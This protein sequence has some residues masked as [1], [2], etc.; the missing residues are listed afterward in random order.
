M[1]RAINIALVGFNGFRY[2]NNLKYL[3]EKH[4]NHKFNFKVVET[5]AQV[6]FVNADSPEGRDHLTRHQPSFTTL[7]ASEKPLSDSQYVINKPIKSAAIHQLLD[8][9]GSAFI[10]SQHAH[11][12]DDANTDKKA[13]QNVTKM[14]E[15]FVEKSDKSE[16][17]LPGG[18]GQAKEELRFYQPHDYLQGRILQALSKNKGSDDCIRFIKPYSQSELLM[19]ISIAD[20]LVYMPEGVNKIDKF[21]GI[22]MAGT[23]VKT[24]IVQM[25]KN[26]KSEL[27]SSGCMSLDK[28]IWDS[29]VGASLGRLP[30]STDSSTTIKMKYWPNLSRLKLRGG[31]TQIAALW[32]QNSYSI[33]QVRDF[34]PQYSQ[35]INAFYAAAS[36]L[37]LFEGGEHLMVTETAKKVDKGLFNRLFKWIKS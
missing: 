9:A 10:D 19:T 32:T 17:V 33:G 4:G 23:E 8:V 6:R 21:Y 1:K 18:K 20:G 29:A 26:H 36:A 24:Q 2:L 7:V 35:Q 3:I 5:G 30:K 25:D 34:L 16:D 13:K 11:T 15:S 28:L 27:F 37:D 31:F 12:R 22:L 14:P